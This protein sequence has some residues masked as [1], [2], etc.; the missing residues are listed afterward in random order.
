MFYAQ[1]TGGFY[2]PVI[3]GG[4]IP[5]DAVEISAEEY[6]SIIDGQAAGK[7][8]VSDASGHPILQDPPPPTVEQIIDSIAAAVQAHMDAAAKAAGYDDVKSAVT[9]AEE[10]AVQK[11]RAEGQAFR[12]WRSLVWAKCY[13]L[14]AAVQS[15]ARPPMTA[16]QV[17]AELPA[18]NLPT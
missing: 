11:F 14:L 15:G 16:Q 8:I 18:L 17:I 6:A 4:N 13:E 5:A 12:A 1:S 10:P 9:Y 2:S 3:H 7:R